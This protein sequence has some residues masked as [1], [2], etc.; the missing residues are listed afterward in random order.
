MFLTDSHCHFHLLDLTADAGDLDKVIARAT[1]EGVRYFLNVCVKMADFPLLLQIAEKY[2]FVGTSIGLHPNYQ[3]EE[4]DEETLVTLAKHPKVLA[5]G[6]TGLDYF[7]S[8]GDLDWQR[9]RFRTHI[10]AA[11]K[12]NKPIIVHT[13]DAKEDTLKIMKEEGAE[14]VGGVMHC[15][16]EDW[17]TAEKALALGFYISFSGI[18]TFKNAQD[19]QEVAKMV[20]LNRLLIETDAPYLAPHPHR[21]KANE[22]SYIRHTAEFIANLRGLSLD[23]LAEMTTNN[24][25]TLFQGATRPYV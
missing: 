24:F 1:S 22:P 14:Q 6:E 9:E 5:I 2:S 4:V 17:P 11:K 8:S 19:L 18:V 3:D 16:T 10:R 15:F 21:G 13:R 23:Q 25:F 7:R 12:I 20:P